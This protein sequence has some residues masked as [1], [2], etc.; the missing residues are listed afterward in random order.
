MP[1]HDPIPYDDDA[2]SPDPGEAAVHEEMIATFAT[3]QETTSG[4]YGH[5]VRGVHAKSHGLLKGRLEVREGL[6]PALAQGL[7]ATPGSYEVALRLSTNPGDILDDSVSTPRGLAVKVVGVEGARLPDSPG[8]SQDF[9]LANAPAFVAP[10]AK[11]FL[12]SLKLLAATTDTPQIFKKAFSATLRGIEGVIESL[13]GKS[14]TLIALGGHPETHLLG[15]T[16]YSQVPLRWG[17][18]VAKVAVAPVSLE[19]TALTGA[20]LNVNGKPN[21]LREA[22]L[23]YFSAHEAVWELRV[24]LRTNARTMPIEDASVPWPEHESPYVAVAT[25]TV[26]RQ[27]S[28]DEGRIKAIDDG[29][30]FSPWNGLAAHRPLGSIMRARRAAYPRS[31]DFRATRNGCPIH[32]PRDLS[33]IRG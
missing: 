33:G 10:D 29:F 19:L 30:A 24:Q 18:Y 3:I 14:P 20:A 21:G 8:T 5:A 13:G 4:H 12:R 25:I 7:V 11:A 27:S 15:E 23:A 17:D 28:W 26:P 32:D 31:A 16:F 9:V 22:V 2:E 1:L 6:A